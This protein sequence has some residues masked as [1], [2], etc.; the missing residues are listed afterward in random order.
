MTPSGY[1]DES[2]KSMVMM[3]CFLQQREVLE[4]VF[5]LIRSPSDQV[6][7]GRDNIAP[8]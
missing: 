1:G 7:S 2:L 5:C 4:K 8:L 6:P 3:S